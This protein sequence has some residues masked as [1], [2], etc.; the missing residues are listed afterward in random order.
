MALMI[1]SLPR[2][3][4]PVSLEGEMFKALSTLPDDYYVV[5]SFKKFKQM[6]PNFVWSVK[7]T[8][9]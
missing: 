1:P 3:Y 5:H 8:F 6:C 2:D 7:S 4:E 9:K